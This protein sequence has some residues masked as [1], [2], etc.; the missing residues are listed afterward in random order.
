MLDKL[1]KE[2]DETIINVNILSPLGQFVSVNKIY[3]RCP[4]EIQGEVFS[5]DLMKLPFSEFEPIF[6]NRLFIL[7]TKRV[8]LKTF[9]WEKIV[10]VGERKDYLSNV[11]SSLVAKTLVH[12]GCETYLA[13]ILDTSASESFVEN[14]CIM[15]D[16]SDISWEFGID[17]LLGTDPVSIAPYHMA[18]KELVELKWCKGVIDLRSGYYML[19]VK[20][21]NIPKTTFRTRYGHYG[22]C[23]T[24]WSHERF[25]ND[26]LI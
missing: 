2:V 26:I 10:M 14:I 17:L 1:G 16:Y 21:M 6:W 3:K 18:P 13:Y 25:I 4:L 15:R 24:L 22:P 12:K 23:D 20:E 11:I 7:A 8:T 9:I 5:V 19:K